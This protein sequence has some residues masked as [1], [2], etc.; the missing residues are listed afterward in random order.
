MKHLAIYDPATGCLTG[1]CGPEQAQEL[2]AFERALQHLAERGVV[3]DRFNLGYDP[4]EFA[5]NPVVK[6]IIR[7]KG[8]SGLPVV[9]ADGQ[10]ISQGGYPPVSNLGL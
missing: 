4:D 10:V 6:A 5:S 7:D 3:V 1:A 8:M 9:V 2:A